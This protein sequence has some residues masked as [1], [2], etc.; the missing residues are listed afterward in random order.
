MKK[1]KSQ[2]WVDTQA[3]A[4]F[5]IQKLIFGTSGNSKTDIKIFLSCPILLDFVTFHKMSC[6]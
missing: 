5:P 1:K 2:S 6:H 3:S 4:Q